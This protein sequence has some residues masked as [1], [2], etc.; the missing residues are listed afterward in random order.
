MVVSCWHTRVTRRRGRG[1][2]RQ[3]YVSCLLGAHAC[4]P[5][6]LPLL[7]ERSSIAVDPTPPSL[8]AVAGAR[9]P[10][11]CNVFLRLRLRVLC[12][13]PSSSLT[14]HFREREEGTGG[15]EGGGGRGVKGEGGGEGRETRAGAGERNNEDIFFFAVFFTSS[16]ANDVWKA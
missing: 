6:C 8:P 7:H 14:P 1:T 16:R 10:I 9:C 13:D 5:A 2:S 4:L 12:G 11:G 3:K 15:G